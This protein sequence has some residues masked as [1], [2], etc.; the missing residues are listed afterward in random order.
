[1]CVCSLQLHSCYN[2]VQC[3]SHIAKPSSVTDMDTAELCAGW[4]CAMIFGDT[5]RSEARLTDPAFH[6]YHLLQV[7]R[8][9]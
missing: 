1:M 2:G 4:R 9:V 7:H 5:G 6:L 8:V 3:C